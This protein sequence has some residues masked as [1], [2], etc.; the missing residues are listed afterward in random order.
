MTPLLVYSLP[1]LKPKITEVLN[2][3]CDCGSGYER[4]AQNKEATVHKL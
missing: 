2:F 1:A 3:S 4:A